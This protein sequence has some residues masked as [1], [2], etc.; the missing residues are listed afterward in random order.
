MSRPAK[1]AAEAARIAA[2][3]AK[4]I[5]RVPSVCVSVCVG[6]LTARRPVG[7]DCVMYSPRAEMWVL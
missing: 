3:T 1:G 4:E 2:E 6:P 5:E 7:K